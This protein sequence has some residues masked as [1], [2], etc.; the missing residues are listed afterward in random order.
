MHLPVLTSN[1]VELRADTILVIESA[2][3]NVPCRH[4]V[5][6]AVRWLVRVLDRHVV[7]SNAHLVGHREIS[8]GA[9]SSLA[10]QLLLEHSAA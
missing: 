8:A 3:L 1:D 2:R 5:E 7:S 6:G 9:T 10:H 4:E